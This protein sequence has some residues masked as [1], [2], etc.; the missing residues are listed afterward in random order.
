[1][2]RIGGRNV[3]A[4]LY[5]SSS[6]IVIEDI[7]LPV[8]KQGEVLVKVDYAG[9]C[10]TDMLIYSGNH[11]RVKAPLV[12][13]HEFSGQIIEVREQ[14]KFSIGDNVVV[15]PTISCGECTACKKGNFNV[16]KNLKLI[17]IDINGGFSEY[18]AVPHHR[19]H[20]IPKSLSNIHASLSEPVAVGV[21]NIRK[22]EMKVGDTIAI[23][24]AGPIGLIIAMIAKVSGA[25]D[26]YITDISNYRLEKAR[27]LGF[28]PI[29][30]AEC[31]VIS[32]IKKNTNNE[33]VDIVFEAAGNNIT[34]KQMTELVGI[35]GKI[36]IVSVYKEP[37]LVDLATMHFKELSMISTRCY[38]SSDFATAINIIASRQIDVD[39]LI[40]HIISLDD[41]KRGFELMKDVEKSV[42]VIFQVSK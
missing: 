7:E 33:G 30:S 5:K 29:N 3:K 25:K 2:S 15:E 27:E 16:C 12:M 20:L 18:V 21:H 6:N 17:G 38:S 4:C 40:S 34:A 9:I 39:I 37:S 24:G 32:E 13:G 8:L 11:P 35:Q 14:T 19:I 22:S 10:G 41:A 42:K 23:L 1:M 28:I 31:N 36:V 26:I